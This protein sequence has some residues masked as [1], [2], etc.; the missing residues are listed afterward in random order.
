MADMMMQ[1]LTVVGTVF[2]VEPAPV[3]AGM[4]VVGTVVS[5]EEATAV[6]GQ[7]WAQV[8]CLQPLAAVVE[9]HEFALAVVE[10]VQGADHNFCRSVRSRLA[11]RYSVHNSFSL[12]TVLGM[13]WV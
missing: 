5:K 12:S 6:A 3:V 2:A 7:V 8:L 9:I 10:R 11:V 1:V 13:F 4:A